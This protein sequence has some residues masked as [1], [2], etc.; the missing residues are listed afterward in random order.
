VVKKSA[1]L[2]I[3]KKYVIILKKTIFFSAAPLPRAKK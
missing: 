2:T 1:R 3:K